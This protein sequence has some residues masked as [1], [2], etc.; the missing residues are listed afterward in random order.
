MVQ[1]EQQNGDNA[2]SEVWDPPTKENFEHEEDWVKEDYKFPT[3]KLNVSNHKFGDWKKPPYMQGHLEQ[4]Q[5]K[6][7]WVPM[8]KRTN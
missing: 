7:R 5:G 1:P 8:R 3:F 6:R 2:T 4:P